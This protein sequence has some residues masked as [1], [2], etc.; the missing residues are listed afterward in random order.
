M[1]EITDAMIKVHHPGSKS[2]PATTKRAGATDAGAAAVA[3]LIILAAVNDYERFHGVA[4]LRAKLASVEGLAAKLESCWP[5]HNALAD[6][7]Y[8]CGKAFA[9]SVDAKMIRDALAGEPA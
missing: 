8:A 2:S 5:V 1:V 7:P 6:D 3:P 4:E 9:R